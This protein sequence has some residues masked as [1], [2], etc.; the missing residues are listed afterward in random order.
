MISII[1]AT[2]KD[3][4]AIVR[5]GLSAVAEAHRDSCSAA[6]LKDY[7][8][9]NYNLDAIKAELNDS[10]NIYHIIYYNG[11]PAGFSKIVLNAKHPNIPAENTTKL[12]RIYL[13]KEFYGMKLGAELLKVNNAYAKNNGQSGIWL[14][15]WIGN[16]HAIEFYLKAGFIIIGSHDFY[17]TATHYNP[18]HHMFLN[19]E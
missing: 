19:L 15:T 8:D 17:V 4:T 5:I 3:H 2:E 9:R 7:L 11:D 13:L 6:D 1:K 14:F 10:D 18:N 16:T 12:D